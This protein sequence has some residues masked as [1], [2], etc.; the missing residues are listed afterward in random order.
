MSIV[1]VTT[2]GKQGKATRIDM[3]RI[4][5]CLLNYLGKFTTDTDHT[6]TIGLLQ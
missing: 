5:I 1:P 4:E 2:S 6:V 3:S